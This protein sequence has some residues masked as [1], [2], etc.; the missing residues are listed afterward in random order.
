[1]T[2]STIYTRSNL[3]SVQ[4]CCNIG[5][6]WTKCLLFYRSQVV[7][8][9]GFLFALSVRRIEC[10][11]VC[12]MDLD[13]VNFVLLGVKQDCVALAAGIIHGIIVCPK[14]G[15]SVQNDAGCRRADY[16]Q[17]EFAGG[18][19][20]GSLMW[21]WASNQIFGRCSGS[22]SGAGRPLRVSHGQC[23]R[24]WPRPSHVGPLFESAA[25]RPNSIAVVLA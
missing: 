15:R 10:T 12:A 20:V 25:R 17:A 11:A 19:I 2:G 3:K 21:R 13:S 7:E 8:R 18:H 9:R 16:F 23:Q 6:I 24:L 1:M 14:Y 22:C 4:R 5:M